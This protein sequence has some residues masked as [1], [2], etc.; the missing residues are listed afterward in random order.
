M[1]AKIQPMASCG[2]GPG[3]ARRRAAGP[4]GRI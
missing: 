1:A 2:L 3:L 4:A